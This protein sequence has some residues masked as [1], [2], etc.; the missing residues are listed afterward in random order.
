M[1]NTMVLAAPYSPPPP[2]VSPWQ[3]YSLQWRGWDGSVWD[4]NDPAAGVQV[5]NTG[6]V[7]LHLPP[8]E[9]QVSDRRTGRRRRGVRVRERKVEIPILLWH[10]N[11]S[12]G[13]VERDRGFWRSWDPL[14]PGT[15]TVTAPGGVVRHLDL[16]LDSDGAHAYELDPVGAGWALYQVE[17]TAEQPYFYGDEIERSWGQV[18]TQ[19][20]FGGGDPEDPEAVE[21][22]PPFYVSSESNVGNAFMPNPGDVDSWVTWVIT[23][24]GSDVDVT[25]GSIGHTIGLPTIPEGSTA[26][27][28]T[29]PSVATM[30]IDG[31]DVAGQVDPYNP[32]P[33]PASSGRYV[34]ITMTGLGTVT[35]RLTPR[36]LRGW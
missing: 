27:V 12:E 20:F 11:T 30:T 32:E 36:Y 6:L 18:E 4:L 13:W 31:A 10:D 22:A 21:E 8:W 7:G 5:V 15:L 26:V 19:L 1:P 3:G 17:A 16:V 14:R 33:I 2:K 24:T 25:V 34:Q 35:A 29:D 23:A 28:N 9:A